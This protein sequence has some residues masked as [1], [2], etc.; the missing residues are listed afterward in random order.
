MFKHEHS[1]PTFERIYSM[2]LVALL[3][4]GAY[5]I[6]AINDENIPKTDAHTDK[7]TARV[8]GQNIAPLIMNFKKYGSNLLLRLPL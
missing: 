7:H 6:L 8:A 5:K 2:F 4:T 1:I 3:N